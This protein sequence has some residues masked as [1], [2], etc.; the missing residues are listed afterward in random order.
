MKNLEI[1]GLIL[2]EYCN[3]T[4]TTKA[5]KDF[6]ADNLFLIQK[7]TEKK[8]KKHNS[9]TQWLVMTLITYVMIHIFLF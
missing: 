6:E 9:M 4:L 3:L 7:K 1:F 5:T 2:S 8:R